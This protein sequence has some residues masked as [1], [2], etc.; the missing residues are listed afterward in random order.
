MTYL[1]IVLITAVFTAAA[2]LLGPRP[3]RK[4]RFEREV[5]RMIAEQV[6]AS[7]RAG[8]EARRLVDAH[9][10]FSQLG[11]TPAEIAENCRNIF[12]NGQPMNPAKVE[13]S[14]E[15]I[16]AEMGV[17]RSGLTIALVCEY[18][19]RK[20]GGS[21]SME[22]EIIEADLIEPGIA[23]DIATIEGRKGRLLDRGKRGPGDLE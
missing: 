2:V 15:R 10:R 1:A 20:H 11:V 19:T 5:D 8:C 14:L 4:R 3:L 23:G 17:P 21:F 9:N 6:K 13:A 7:P 16:A 18:M 12:V 22:V